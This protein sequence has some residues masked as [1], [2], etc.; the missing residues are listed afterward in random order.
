[1]GFTKKAEIFLSHI[2]TLSRSLKVEKLLESC[3]DPLGI[4][5]LHNTIMQSVSGG[6][7]HKNNTSCLLMGLHHASV[8]KISIV[9]MQI[10]PQDERYYGICASSE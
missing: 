2:L 7:L 8:N 5:N 10:T 4:H 1:M 6:S 9:L 3:L